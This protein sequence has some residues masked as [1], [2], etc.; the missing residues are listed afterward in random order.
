VGAPTLPERAGPDRARAESQ[1]DPHGA[2]ARTGRSSRLAGPW[3]AIFL[4]LLVVLVA[5]AA[6]LVGLVLGAPDNIASGIR[7][8]LGVLS[9]A[10]VFVALLLA[11]AFNSM[12]RA[13]D[14]S[15][16]AVRVTNERFQ[17]ALAEAVEVSEHKSAFVANISHEIRTPLNGVVGMANLLRD[18][19][20]D[21]VQ[22]EYADALA[23][24][25]DALLAVINDILD[26]SKIE[27]GRLELDATDFELR[28]AVGEA[29]LML[30]SQARAK[31]LAIRHWLDAGVPITVTGDRVRLR[32]I[33]LNLLSNA[34]KFTASGEITVNV[35]DDGDSIVR[36]EVADTGVGIHADQAIHVFESFVQADQSTTR[37]YGGTGLGLAISRELAHRMGGEIGAKPGED[38]G[39][40]FWFT[41][42]LPAVEA[43]AAGAGPGVP[44]HLEGAVEAK[45]RGERSS[46]VVLVAEDNEINHAVATALL[47][48][49]GL[50]TA[51]AHNGREAVE[52]A[53]AKEYAAILMDC[54]MP[55]VDGYEATRRIRAAESARRV[56]IIAMTAHSMPGDRERCLA[57]GMDDY[58]SKPVRAEELR[59]AMGTWLYEDATGHDGSS[60]GAPGEH[61]P[62]LG[63]VGERAGSQLEPGA[64]AAAE[65]LDADTVRELRDTLTLAMRGA[66]IETFEAALPA[67][68][69]DIVGAAQRGDLLELRRAAHLLKG[70]AATLGAAR[71]S[72]ACHRLEQS[73]PDRDPSVGDDELEMLTATAFATRRALSEQLL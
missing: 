51:I 66:L 31:G 13:L 15:E 63:T 36:F 72:I 17:G 21:S 62:R 10:L 39:S 27:A 22:R 64:R 46:A 69:A 52:M 59:A 71:L 73:R 42:S 37:R 14:E 35:F 6:V 5:L 20:L 29:C 3:S 25:S 19:Q 8:V 7:V 32:Q 67:S 41:A 2:Q 26:F 49:L 28:P 43:S 60:N 56:P 54:Q 47:S 55:E 11:G 70:S 16:R 30:A 65:L 57:A 61:V 4:V 12:T 53:L 1:A 45:T 48:K 38:G 58:L 33:L 9:A 34:V 44:A 24:S 23:A 18:T 68:V 40:V 50:R